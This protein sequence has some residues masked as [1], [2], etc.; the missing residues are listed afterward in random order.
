M[1]MFDDHYVSSHR[2]ERQV[3]LVNRITN[4]VVNLLRALNPCLL[5]VVVLQT[6]EEC[7]TQ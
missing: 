1:E 4:L 7:A 3:H 5:V 2:T 6:Y